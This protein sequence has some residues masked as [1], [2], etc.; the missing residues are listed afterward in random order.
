M[1][2]R[3]FQDELANL[4][5]LGAEFSESHPAIA[6]MLSGATTDPDV[7]RLLE[8]V[9]FLTAL[10]RQKLDDEFPEVIHELI[11]LIWPHYLR[12]VP[13]S[14]VVAFTPK[15]TLKQSAVVPAGIHLGSVP[16][17]GTPC[18]FRTCYDVELH[19]IQ[20][21]EA[22][23]VEASGKP[24]A[25]R[26]VLELRGLKLSDWSPRALRFFLSGSYAE[27]T[28]LYLLLQRYLRQVVITPLD[29]GSSVTL[30]PENIRPVA[31]SGD[32][33]LIP[34]PTR[35]FPGYRILQEYFILPER[36]LFLDLLGWDHWI[37]R[38]DGDRFEISFELNE[39]PFGTPRIK[40][41][42]FVLSATPAINVFPQD[43]EPIRLDHKSA[44]YPVRPAGG[45]A[46]HYQVY[47]LQNVV[48]F[49]QGTAEQREYVPFE[50][51]SPQGQGTPVYHVTVRRSPTKSV[52]DVY[53]SVAYPPEMKLSGSET[54]SI[55]LECTN[56]ALPEGLQVGDI[57]VPTSDSP[58]FA[59]FRNIRAP[60]ATVL[61]PLGKNL[62]WRL[63]SHMSLNYTSLAKAENLKAVLE[64]YV[65]DET[66]D[67]A[68]VIANKKRISGIEEVTASSSNKLVSG[69]MMRGQEIVVKI[70][71]D[72]FAGPGDLFLFGSVLDSFLGSYA[73]MNTYTQL[74]VEEV[75]RGD[76]YKW[77]ARIGEHFLI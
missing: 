13:C 70:R 21:V 48:G 5:D 2:D 11:R 28:D 72:H 71:E 75:S 40:R 22:T 9:A 25:I 59:E 50:V 24:P 23:F 12:P 20:L 16:V 19:P 63:L 76:R 33:G 39:L 44:E 53:L 65:F 32:E 34:Y 43:A 3:Y 66:R 18:T 17:E 64:L 54:L 4:R 26:L 41:D 61:P 52:S 62:L 69:V 55:R 46:D 74:V 8:G 57:S 49:V 42:H 36:F 67:R 38:G 6:P 30:S 68:G 77:P 47:S 29:D 51:F 45:S 31:F 73:S 58:E 7:E 35:S 60:S 14:T 15:P 56:G 37:N 27:A 1:F 10:L